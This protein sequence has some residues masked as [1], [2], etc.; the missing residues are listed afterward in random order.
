MPRIRRSLLPFF[1]ILSLLLMISFGVFW[2]ISFSRA[3]SVELTYD[4][5]P[6][7]SHWFSRF[8][9]IEL[10]KGYRRIDWGRDQFY[11]EHPEDIVVGWEEK[12]AADFARKHPAGFTKHFSTFEVSP[13]MYVPRRRDQP[14]YFAPV[15]Y[16]A[17]TP[18]KYG[19]G[20]QRVTEFN[21]IGRY[22]VDT[23]AV[24]PGWISAVVITPAAIWLARWARHRR[25]S[26]ASR[27]TKCGYDLRA[28]PD[29]CPECGTAPRS[30]QTASA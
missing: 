24:A 1:A 18:H 6:T 9:N 10:V 21:S 26:H 25:R 28:T 4:V 30:N 5:W 29:R 8:L 17:G 13:M 15:D 23:T 12:D 11:L 7:R 14:G 19:F 2:Y 16:L 20:C 27:C 22:D 3:F